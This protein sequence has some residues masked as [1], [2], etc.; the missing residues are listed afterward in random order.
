MRKA[1]IR[2]ADGFVENIIEIKAKSKWQPPENCYLIDA[3][4][5]SPGDTWD[6]TKFVKP[7]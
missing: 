2:N 4:D 3:S 6:G 7:E 1:V 5:G